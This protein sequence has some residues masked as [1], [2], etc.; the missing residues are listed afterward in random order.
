[1]EDK[2]TKNVSWE[3]QKSILQ[4]FAE[5]CWKILQKSRSRKYLA[6][7]LTDADY[8]DEIA[9]FTDNIK[10]AEILLHLLENAAANIGLYVN[11]KK[12]KFATLNTTG[13]IEQKPLKN[14]KE[15]TYRGSNIM[16]TKKDIKS[17]VAKECSWEKEDW[18]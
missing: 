14:V 15:F 16:S 10:N 8:V 5:C 4:I 2:V 18:L 7:Y 11:E 9:L 1:M 12:T 6:T 13:T 3:D 17:F